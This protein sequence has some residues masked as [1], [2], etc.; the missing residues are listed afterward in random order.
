MSAEKDLRS[1][2]A[3]DLVAEMEIMGEKPFRAQQIY[4]W[5]W[6]KRVRHIDEM[7][8][9]P[10]NLRQK[11]AKRFTIRTLTVA[12]KQLSSDG[13]VKFAFRTFDQRTIESVLIP[14]ESRLTV[15]VSSQ[16]G[17]SLSCSFCATGQLKRMRNLS[18]GEI[19]DQVWE[20]QQEA[21]RTYQRP[22]TNIVY[23]GMG[24]PLL[25]FSEV[26]ESIGHITSP[27][28]LGMSPSRITVST[29]G[30]AKM[31]ETLAERA[32]KVNLALS[33]HAPDDV[34]RTAIM[35][36]NATNNLRALELALKKY[37]SI[38]GQP[39]TFEYILLPNC[40]D[41]AE[42]AKKL[43]AICKRH[44]V[45]VNL[46]EYNPIDGAEFQRPTEKEL[47]NFKRQL[48]KA[49]ITATIRHSRGRDID[50]ACGQLAN[51]NSISRP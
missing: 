45:K 21:Q 47:E 1:L 43:A 12:E 7:R 14:T 4:S 48:E 46:I 15:C 11:L 49:G 50:A 36:I 5:L 9:L 26:V 24:E 37:Y 18:A 13:T 35:P 28:G 32:P 19:F 22:L 20:V 2:S 30:I 44:P 33:L 16:V 3:D 8:N 31:I 29:A 27:R 41:S 38:T 17:C 39:F 51:K 6:N 34:K 40:N 25:N 42:D 23:M 10:A